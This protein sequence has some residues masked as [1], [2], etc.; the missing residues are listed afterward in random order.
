MKRAFHC[1]SNTLRQLGNKTCPLLK[2]HSF[3]P[4]AA[5]FNVLGSRY[6][7]HLLSVLGVVLSA[8]HYY[9]N[10]THRFLCSGYDRTNVIKPK[11]VCV[12]YQY[13]KHAPME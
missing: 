11:I 6:N 4:K 12:V 2:L 8:E 13:T 7:D 1:I 5:Y 9:T 10:T 3:G